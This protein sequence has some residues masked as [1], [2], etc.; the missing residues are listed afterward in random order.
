VDFIVRLVPPKGN[1]QN[2][3]R[4][5]TSKRW[6]EAGSRVP[7]L[8]I[9]LYLGVGTLACRSFPPLAYDEA[10]FAEVSWNFSTGK[11][12]RYHLLDD[13]FLGT[14]IPGYQ[15]SNFVGRPIAVAWL[16]LWMKITG[17]NFWRFRLSGIVVGAG[18]RKRLTPIL[19]GC[20]R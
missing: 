16:G 9:A 10:F 19:P 8:L 15:L 17:R 5:R 7:A 18:I 12:I 14:T 2:R 20:L 3:S 6:R 13:V 4:M 1:C 11:G